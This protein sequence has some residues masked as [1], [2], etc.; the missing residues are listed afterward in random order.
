MTV[1]H[2]WAISTQAEAMDSDVGCPLLEYV[3]IYIRYSTDLSS[4]SL[5][6]QAHLEQNNFISEFKAEAGAPEVGLLEFDSQPRRRQRRRHQ[7]PGTPS[8]RD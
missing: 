4:D 8:P 1:H 6:P 3:Y 7:R 2:L 5:M